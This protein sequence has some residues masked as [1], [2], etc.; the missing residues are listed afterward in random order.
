MLLWPVNEMSLRV[1]LLMWLTLNL[2]PIIQCL[3]RNNT[4]YNL[5]LK[6]IK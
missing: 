6:Y 5:H 3:S 4:A 1:I 2:A